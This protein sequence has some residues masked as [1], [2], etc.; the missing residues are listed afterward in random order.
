VGNLP[1][2]LVDVLS[3]DARVGVVAIGVE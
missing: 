2:A 1:V 3:H